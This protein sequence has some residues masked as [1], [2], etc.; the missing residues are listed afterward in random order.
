MVIIERVGKEQ[1]EVLM[2]PSKITDI[3]SS[4]VQLLLKFQV[5]CIT[6]IGLERFENL[7]SLDELVTV[8]ACN[9]NRLLDRNVLRFVSITVS[10]PLAT[11]GSPKDTEFQSTPAR[12]AAET[13]RK[14]IIVLEFEPVDQTFTISVIVH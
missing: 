13:S 6:G 10:G 12:N 1:T 8:L 7:R 14:L 2:A 11:V 4:L 5:L 3:G 9:L